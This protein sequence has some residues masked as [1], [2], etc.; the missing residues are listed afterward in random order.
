[1]ARGCNKG[2][3]LCLPSSAGS[4]REFVLWVPSICNCRCCYCLAPNG[5]KRETG[6]GMETLDAAAAI[7]AAS[8]NRRHEI[9]DRSCLC[10]RAGAPCGSGPDNG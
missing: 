2:A 4:D 7:E 8:Q 1:M 9:L 10:V 3:L 5:A 6:E